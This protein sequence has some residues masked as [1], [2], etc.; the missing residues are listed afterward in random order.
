VHLTSN[1]LRLRSALFFAG[2][3][4]VALLWLCLALK[5]AGVV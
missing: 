1:Y 5:L 2:A 3:V 4:L